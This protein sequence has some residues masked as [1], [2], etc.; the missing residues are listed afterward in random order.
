MILAK[1]FKF[2]ITTDCDV[3]AKDM[4]LAGNSY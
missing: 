2:L 1:N 4:A 3:R